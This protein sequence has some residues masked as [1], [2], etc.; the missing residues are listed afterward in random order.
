MS[1]PLYD[2]TIPAFTRSL[3]AL[4]A[5]L[6]KAQ[7]HADSLKCD[8]GNILGSRLAPD[9]FALSRQ[10]QIACDFAKSISSRMVGA[11]VP[12]Y[13]DNEVTLAKPLPISTPLRPSSLKVRKSE[14]FQSRCVTA[15]SVNILVRRICIMP[16]CRIFIF[17]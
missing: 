11:E 17:T 15:A 6:D 8:I 1:H 14:Q 10:I 2:A 16:G 7:A 5:C 13:E 4:D 12:S 9:M 3:N